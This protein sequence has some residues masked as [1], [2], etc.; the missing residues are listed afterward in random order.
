MVPAPP[1]R[2]DRWFLGLMVFLFIINLVTMYWF[3]VIIWGVLLLQFSLRFGVNRYRRR[4]GIKVTLVGA[5]RSDI[6]TLSVSWVLF[7]LF[8]AL[9]LLLPNSP[10][11]TL[12]AAVILG[13]GLFGVAVAIYAWHNLR[14]PQ[15][16]YKRWNK[17]LNKSKGKKSDQEAGA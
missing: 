7:C 10:M 4:H 9:F 2:F 15:A 5:Q 11:S 16:L 12:G 13:L 1:S 3:S 6:K 14:D 17:A 8:G